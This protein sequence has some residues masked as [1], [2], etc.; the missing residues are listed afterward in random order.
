MKD[1]FKRIVINA[2]DRNEIRVGFV[3]NGILMELYYESENLRSKV[4]N[5]YFA[6]VDNVVEGMDAAFLDIG[7]GKKAFLRSKDLCSVYRKNKDPHITSLKKGQRLIVQVKK[8]S[9][10]NKGPQVTTYVSVTGR[11][12]VYLPYSKKVS[13]SRK[14]KEKGERNRLI[15]LVK[16]L[17]IGN[18]GFIIRTLAKAMDETII[19]REAKELVR[20]WKEIV[21]KTSEKEPPV[22]LYEEPNLVDIIL[23][24]KINDVDEIVVDDLELYRYVKTKSQGLGISVVFYG[25]DDVFS[26]YGIE[27]QIPDSL[28]KKVTLRCGGSIYI[29]KTEALTVIDVNAGR[30]VKNGKEEDVILETNM[31]AAKEIARQM[32]LRN[33][34]GIIV[35]DF[36]DMANDEE[37]EQVKKTLEKEMERDKTRSFVV[38]FTRLGLLEMTRKRTLRTVYSSL[39]REC[40]FCKGVGFIFRPEIVVDKIKNDLKK[41]FL[42]KKM[43]AVELKVGEEAGEL[44]KMKEKER[45]ERELNIK[46]RIVSNNIYLGRYE[47]EVIK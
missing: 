47:I 33:L 14:I 27:E 19:E 31:E 23:R 13:I 37:R 1:F 44:F 18:G 17:K 12:L 2:N 26:H 43:S 6:R 46:I 24:D 8:D 7:K 45:L 29:Q 39:Q 41:M 20:S 38:G 34:S 5:L 30:N 28:D 3:E 22:L 9:L 36:I 32:R 4:G 25:R 15:K 21:K 16:G 10:S 42:N 40:P 35:V 11:Y